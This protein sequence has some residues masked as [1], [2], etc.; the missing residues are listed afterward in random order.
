MVN[1]V[2]EY[3]RQLDERG[4]IILP[5]K[6]REKMS[7][8]VYVTRSMSDRCLH[9]YTQEEWDKIS[10]KITQLPTATD[11]NAAAFVRIFFGKAT[12]AAVDKQGRI[13]IAKRLIDYAQ[14]KKDVVLVGANTRL[15]IWDS[16]QWDNYQC[17]LSDDFML[18][19]IREYGLNI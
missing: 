14:L 11:R 18:S 17:G 15:E 7:D 12:A 9:L 10:E 1:F 4:R 19:G 2:D 6:V 8:T 3:P 13:P 16:A 5:A